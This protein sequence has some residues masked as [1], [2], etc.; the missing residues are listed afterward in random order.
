MVNVE[1]AT[2]VAKLATKVGFFE[3]ALPRL[4]PFRRIEVFPVRH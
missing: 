2:I 3:L 1:K 4:F